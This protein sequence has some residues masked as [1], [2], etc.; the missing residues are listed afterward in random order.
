MSCRHRWTCR[1]IRSSLA[2]PRKSHLSGLRIRMGNMFRPPSFLRKDHH[3]ERAEAQG[4]GQQFLVGLVF[5][6]CKLAELPVDGFGEVSGNKPLP[7]AVQPLPAY[8]F[9]QVM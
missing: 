3:V 5:I 2:V 7:L 4:L 1:N 6:E 8:T 9:F